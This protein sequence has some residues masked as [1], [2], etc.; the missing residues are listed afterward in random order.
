MDRRGAHMTDTAAPITRSERITNLD[1]VR[2]IATLG[3]LV[4]NAVSF[5]LPQPAYFNLDYAGSDTA[6]DWIVGVLGEVFVDQKTMA[7]FSMLFGAGIVVFAD[8]AAAKGRR[9]NWLSLWRNTLLL[10]IGLVH[11]AFW[12]GDV[13]MLY[14]ICSPVLLL[15]RT[16]SAR[17]LFIIGG[18]CLALS[19]LTMA[20]IQA[21]IEAGDLGDYWT[22]ENVEQSEDV[23]FAF[24][25]DF[26][27][28]ALGAMLIGVGLF[29]A[30]IIQGRQPAEFYRRLAAWSLGI[31]MPLSILGV[32]IHLANDWSPDVALV[33]AIPNILATVPM[34]IGY[35]ALITLWNQR[36]DTRLH[37]RVRAVGRMALTNYLTQTIMGLTILGAMI[38]VG[39]LGRAEIFVFIL[40]VWAVQLAWSEPWLE[41]F[42]F[43]P[44]EWLWRVATYRKLQPIR[45]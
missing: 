9:A 12:F 44:F 37:E 13:L 31:G 1:T 15:L 14:A 41:R 20:A 35:I 27:M 43:G 26:G 23:Q 38:G 42:R 8:R 6:L 16:R 36:D 3:I 45:R 11:A 25:A 40:V 4:M 18:V 5:G 21:E 28:R 24:I 17:T 2:G 29:R 32:A 34:A 33:G 10:V 22:D 7:M 39:E 19:A 30:D